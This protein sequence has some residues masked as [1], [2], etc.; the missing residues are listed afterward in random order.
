MEALASGLPALVSDIPG[1]REW[2]EEGKQGWLFPAN[3]VNAL[4]AA[5]GSAREQ[6]ADFGEMSMTARK[7]AEAGGDWAQNQLGISRAYEMAIRQNE[8]S[9]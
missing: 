7:Q 5:I 4:A 1:N 8:A 2:V 3:N 6:Q 9:A